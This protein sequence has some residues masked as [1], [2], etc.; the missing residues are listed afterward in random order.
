MVCQ[1]GRQASATL[2]PEKRV[3]PVQAMPMTGAALDQGFTRD[4]Y[5]VI[6]DAQE[7]GALEVRG[8][9]KPFANWLWADRR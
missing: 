9:Y 1:A 5:L 3:Y 4:I 8:Y 6:G 2:R 7:G